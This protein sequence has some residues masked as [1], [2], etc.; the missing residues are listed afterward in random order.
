MKGLIFTINN[1]EVFYEPRRIVEEAQR[2]QVAIDW[3]F[4][5]DFRLRFTPDSLEIQNNDRRVDLS[6]Y[7]F[8]IPRSS[9]LTSGHNHTDLK[10][11]L[12][13]ELS[14]KKVLVVNGVAFLRWMHF[15][16]LLQHHFLQGN[17]LPY[18]ES[19]FMA[20]FKPEN[21][22]FDYPFIA[23][24]TLGSLGKAVYKVTE[25]NE[26]TEIMKR[27][28]PPRVMMQKFL[29]TGEDYR[30][31]VVGG[32][33]V[34]AMRR[35]V[36]KGSHVSNVSSGGKAESAPLTKQMQSIAEKVS[37][38]FGLD[39]CGVD[40]MYDRKGNPYVLE[41]NRHP[42]FRGFE[43]ATGTNVAKLIIDFAVSRI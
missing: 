23:K 19:D 11:V 7:D 21:I 30:V 2:S 15:S 39:F 22:L 42:Q 33:A 35:I 10:T 6:E 34:G 43:R 38:V 12:V 40:I 36:P 37:R 16:K 41:V 5:E 26:L 20:T 24:D 14:D 9:V 31:L 8:A 32:K 18:V 1:E 29:P 27:H 3:M 28:T 13:H 4:Y 17:N 25:V